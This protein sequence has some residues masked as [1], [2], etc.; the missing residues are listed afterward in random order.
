[1]PPTDTTLTR[2]QAQKLALKL[3]AKH[4]LTADG[5]AFQWSQGKRRLGET[6]IQQH[7]DPRTGKT[8]QRKTIRLSKHLVA[9][10]PEAVVRDVI[11]HEIAHA[12][13]GIE[14]GHNHLWRAACRKV[15]AKP[16]RLADE[17]VE[18]V[19]GRYALICNA[20]NRELARRHR[21]TTPGKL[22][23]A[24]CKACGPSSMGKL[25]IREVG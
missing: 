16:Q 19:P 18:T 12:I 22:K 8:T 24:Y 11:L 14:N 3:M 25:V 15:G 17:S 9:M 21:R 20:C 1:M 6:R 13:A 5:W 4:G 10:N 7:R 23:N 2:A